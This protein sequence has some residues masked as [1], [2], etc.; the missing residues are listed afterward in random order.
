MDPGTII[1]LVGSVTLW[2]TTVNTT[3][4]NYSNTSRQPRPIGE[5]C[6]VHDGNFQVL[7]TEDDYAL[8]EWQPGEP[9]GG[10]ACDYDTQTV[11]KISK[12]QELLEESVK[13]QEK[14]QEFWSRVARLQAKY[15]NSQSIFNRLLFR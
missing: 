6:V 11:L 2:I 13:E 3:E 8:V 1:A 15:R 7:A 9:P 14:K 5:I 4:V 10:T 12:L